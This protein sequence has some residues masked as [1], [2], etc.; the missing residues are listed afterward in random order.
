[1]PRMKASSCHLLD[2]GDLPAIWQR[3]RKR[4]TKSL[5]LMTRLV[6]IVALLVLL[7]LSAEGLQSHNGKAVRSTTAESFGGTPPPYLGGWKFRKWK[8]EKWGLAKVCGWIT[9]WCR[10]PCVVGHEWD[11]AHC[12]WEVS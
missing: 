9:G 2:T 5:R 6:W 1:M 8:A 11:V 3:I 7:P 12:V 4:E 10:R